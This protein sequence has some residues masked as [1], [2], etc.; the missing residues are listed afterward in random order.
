MVL[1][2][3]LNYLDSLSTKSMYCEIIDE[4]HNIPHAG[5]G[6]ALFPEKLTGY[7]EA[8]IPYSAFLLLQRSDRALYIRR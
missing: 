1:I 8:N 7:S 2:L 3:L 4:I 6:V 5:F